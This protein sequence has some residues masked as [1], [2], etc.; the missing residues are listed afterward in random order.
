MQQPI[1]PTAAAQPKLLEE[2]WPRL[3]PLLRAD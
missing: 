3:E 1:E 2:V